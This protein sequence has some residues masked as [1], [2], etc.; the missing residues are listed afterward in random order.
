MVGVVATTGGDPVKVASQLIIAYEALQWAAEA[1]GHCEDICS[2]MSKKACC[3]LPILCHLLTVGRIYPDVYDSLNTA[4]CRCLADALVKLQ[5]ACDAMYEFMQCSTVGRIMRAQKTRAKLKMIR[6]TMKKT[7]IETRWYV[8]LATYLQEREGLET[9]LPVAAAVEAMWKDLHALQDLS[10]TDR[11]H[12]QATASAAMKRKCK[13]G[14][15]LLVDR[16]RGDV[17]CVALSPDGRWFATCHLEKHLSSLTLSRGYVVERVM[18]WDAATGRLKQA[19]QGYTSTTVVAWSPCSKMLASC[20]C[21][22]K[23]RVWESATGT[24]LHILKGHTHSLECVSWSPCGSMLA[25]CSCD[26]TVRVWNAATGAPMH[27]LHG[28]T[29][30]VQHVS[31]SPCGGILASCSHDCT[32]RVWKAATGTSMHTL[33]GHTDGVPFVSWSPCGGM[34]TSCS[35]DCTVRVCDAAKGTTR[36]TLHGHTDDVFYVIWSPC[37]GMLASCSRDFTVRVWKAATGTSLHTLKGHTDQVRCIA[38]SL[39]G[40][41]LASGS[42]DGTV[43]LC[44]M[45]TGHTKRVLKPG[46]EVHCV[47]W[48]PCGRFLFAAT[49]D[50]TVH[51][52]RAGS[53]QFMV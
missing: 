46:G 50:C 3:E 36:F 16:R 30:D 4:L 20:S 34:L 31:W 15:V 22:Q 23:V 33:H 37:G 24:S 35:H 6:K 48:S 10:T 12:M 14:Q 13:Q 39:D 29:D 44:D 49:S 5:G 45:A 11:S 51:I 53:G 27:T 19:L 8:S 40:S 28:H 32:V 42:S 43:R 38:W 21:D 7:Y 26:R 18:V 41:L 17:S 2:A 9:G 1:A 47:A 25:S 52:Y